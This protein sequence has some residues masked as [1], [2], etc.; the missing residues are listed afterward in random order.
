MSGKHDGNTTGVT[1][2]LS[3]LDKLHERFRGNCSSSADLGGDGGS[4]E[5]CM[6]LSRCS[7]SDL[8]TGGP[9]HTGQHKQY[10]LACNL[11]FLF[12]V[13]FLTCCTGMLS[14]TETTCFP[15]NYAYRFQISKLVF[16]AV[17]SNI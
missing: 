8:V 2:R 10:Y 17:H 15:Y 12:C 5:G 3:Y 9:L 6:R 1:R 4:E 14:Q 11:C 7:S 16:H 13:V